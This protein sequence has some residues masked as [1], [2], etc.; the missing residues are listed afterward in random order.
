MTSWC[1]LY[2][3]PRKLDVSRQVPNQVPPIRFVPFLASVPAR[4]IDLAVLEACDR[5]FLLVMYAGTPCGGASPRVLRD[6]FWTVGSTQDVTVTPSP[7][8]KNID[9]FGARADILLGVPRHPGCVLSRV[10]A[11]LHSRFGSAFKSPS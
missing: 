4:D 6:L 5:H 1:L 8:G 3:S 2:L 11:P 9:A 7:L 10:L